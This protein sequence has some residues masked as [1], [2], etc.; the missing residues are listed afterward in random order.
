MARDILSEFGPDKK[1]GGGASSG[2]VKSTRETQGYQAPRG[3]KNINDPAGPGLHGHNCGPGGTQGPY[4]T[5]G[6]G[7]SGS[8]GLGGTNHGTAGTQGRR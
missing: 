8:V 3:P 4:A 2:G 7:T 5:R 6:D 1:T